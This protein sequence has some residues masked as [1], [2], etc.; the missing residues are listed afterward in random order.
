M[1]KRVD[2]AQDRDYREALVNTIINLRATKA[3][4]FCLVIYLVKS[5]TCKPVRIQ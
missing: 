3:M 1:R 2:L 4:E 5:F